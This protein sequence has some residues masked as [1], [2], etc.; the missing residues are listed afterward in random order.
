MPRKHVVISG[1]GRAGTSFLIELLTHLGLDTGFLIEDLA[2]H[3]HAS[4]RAGLEHDIRR[5]DAPHIVKSPWFCDHA[6]AILRQ[7]DIVIEHV[8]IPMRDLHAAAESRR[9][10]TDQ[11]LSNMAR[12]R[13]YLPRRAIPGGIWQTRDGSKQEDVLLRK[14]YSLVLSLSKTHTPVTLLHYPRLVT[15]AEYL[16]NKLDPVLEG[17]PFTRFETV[18]HAVAKPDLVHS[19]NFNDC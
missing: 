11:A 15:D 7:H 5:A 4:A 3:K 8:F 16:F 2:K 14:V 1:T 13:R 17:I 9:F 6:E 12:W 19:F 10:V 18:F